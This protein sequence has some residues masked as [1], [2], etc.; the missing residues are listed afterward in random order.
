M[1]SCLLWQ[2]AALVLNPHAD[3]VFFNDLSE[4]GKKLAFSGLLDQSEASFTTPAE[5]AVCDVAIPITYVVC[6]IDKSFPPPAQYAVAGAI[7]AKMVEVSSGHSPMLIEKEAQELVK[8]IV[9]MATQ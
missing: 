7:G 1:D 8:L 9:G 6:T 5:Y 2:G 3:D 4:D